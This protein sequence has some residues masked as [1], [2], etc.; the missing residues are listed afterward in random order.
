ML[1]K[2]SLVDFHTTLSLSKIFSFHKKLYFFNYF[3]LFFIIDVQNSKNE[4]TT[5]D[6]VNFKL[7][8]RSSKSV[9]CL[10]LFLNSL[11]STNFSVL[12]VATLNLADLDLGL[13]VSSFDV[14]LIILFL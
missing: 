6:I 7:A 4:K 14:A 11:G 10:N 13:T 1:N 5:M 3:V 8:M 2:K 12:L 9:R